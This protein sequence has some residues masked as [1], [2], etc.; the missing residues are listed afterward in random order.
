MNSRFNVSRFSVIW[1]RAAIDFVAIHMSMTIALQA[2]IF[3]HEVIGDTG[4]LL[5]LTHKFVSYYCSAFLPL[6]I[7]FTVVLF[8][9]GLYT[10]PLS[11]Q[12]SDRIRR[13]LKSAGLALLSFLV[14][15]YMLFRDSLPGRSVAI[16][17]AFLMPAALVGL[18]VLKTPILEIFQKPTIG[19]RETGHNAVLVI[20]GAGY[21]GSI[22]VRKL[23]AQGRKVR[24]LDSMVYGDRALWE[25]LGHEN[26]SVIVGDCR[27]IQHV[28]QAVRDV[29]SVVL[30]A[31]IVGD[32]A[33]ER[34]RATALEINY[35][36]T[37]MIT[38]VAK[39]HGIRRLIF[40]SSCSV[41]GETQDIMTEE[42]AVHPISCY[43]QTKVDSEFALLQARSETFHPT[44]VRLATVFG[45]SPR[46]R[47]D[48]VV[49]LLTA[50]AYRDH[51]ITIYN[52]EQWRPFVHV[53]DVAEGLLT[54][55]NAPL[56]RVSGQ[57][58]NLGDSR[59]NYTLRDVACELTKIFR[60]LRVEH[61]DNLDRRNYR[62]SFEKIRSE[63]GF[64][65]KH[66][67]RDGIRELADALESGMIVD[68]TDVHYHNQRYLE[69]NGSPVVPEEVDRKVMAA[70]G[71][72][73]P[74]L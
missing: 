14:V 36:A 3:Y 47:F 63:L 49:N 72:P 65:C 73:L 53:G 34:D 8:A 66:T 48:L 71:T 64:Q 6:S 22:L 24:V 9:S 54:I 50:K 10:Q 2:G 23:L 29:D 19:G 21:I 12:R 42:S 13:V 44:I 20:G 26:L 69:K 33:C 70:F 59:L 45:M 39:G 67:L 17:Y 61:L 41:Y 35:A 57:T 25:V 11:Y 28:V 46:P 74:Q 16:A 37:R 55:L 60:N 15:N 62:V 30:L 5:K 56:S 38:E 18:R 31:A 7:L 32:P 51:A 58:F 68:Y 27:H 52:G 43:A 40:A 1:P 4:G